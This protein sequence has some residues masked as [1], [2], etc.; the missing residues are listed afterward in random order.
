MVIGK[1]Y[2]PHSGHHFLIRAA[3][4][5]CQRVTVVVMASRQES[6]PLADRVAWIAERWSGDPHVVVAGIADDLEMDYASE[7]A[8]AGH[9]ALMRRAVESAEPAAPVD[10]VFSSEPYGTELARRFGAAP[11]LLDVG[12]DTFAVSGTKVRADPAAYWDEIEPPVRAALARR[13]VVLGA[14]STGTTTLSRDLAAALRA[15]GGPHASTGW[16]PEYGRELTVAKLAVARGRAAPGD[17]VPT[18]FDLEWTDADFERVVRRQ[19]E[20]EDRA[21]RHGGPVLVCDTDALATTVWQE[22]Y[23]GRTTAAVR[24]AAR[25]IAPRALYLLTDDGGV[26]FADDGLRDGEHLRP[27]MT[28]R[29]REVLAEAGVPWRE[30]RGDRHERLR[31]AL[32]EVDALLARGWGLADPLG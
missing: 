9:V 20:A 28:G 29:L 12:R 14:E 19:T 4:D 1:F 5:A 22:R 7:T 27:W 23:R 8:W 13:V 6:L 2:P 15:R 11:V 30:M 10:A 25:A 24:D 16:V 21:A 32:A 3:A 31:R 26:P 17:P 18:V